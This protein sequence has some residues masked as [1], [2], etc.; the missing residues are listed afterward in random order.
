LAVAVES[1]GA[2][3]S[4]FEPTS[5]RYNW[6]AVWTNSHCEQLVHDQLRAKGL[7][8]FLPKIDVWSRRGGKRH[9]VSTPLFPGYLFLRHGSMDKATFVELCK[10]RG[11]VRVLGERWDRLDV[12][13]D[14]ELDAIGTILRARVPVSRYTYLRDGQPVRILAGPLENIEGVLLRTKLNKGVVVVQVRLLQRG[15]A[16]EIDCTLVAP[17]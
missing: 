17:I 16:V 6:Y 12:V 1:L 5:G 8:L 4:G 13:P 7:E 2:R 10:T 11:L 14:V 15:I 9:L 3:Q